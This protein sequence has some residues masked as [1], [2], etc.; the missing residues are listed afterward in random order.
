MRS[1]A[2]SRATTRGAP[3]RSRWRSPWRSQS[4][5]LKSAPPLTRERRRTNAPD[6][7]EVLRNVREGGLPGLGSER[8]RRGADQRGD[9]GAEPRVRLVRPAGRREADAEDAPPDGRNHA[10]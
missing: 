8:V 5:S 3:T 10:L 7:Q 1:S 2:A 9:R 6:P 4:E